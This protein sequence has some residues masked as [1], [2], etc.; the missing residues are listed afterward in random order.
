MPFEIHLTSPRKS[1]QV[2]EADSRERRKR[3]ALEVIAR[4]HARRARKIGSKRDRIV[5]RALAQLKRLEEKI[6][7]D[8]ASLS[9]AEHSKAILG[10]NQLYFVIAGKP[11]LTKNHII[12]LVRQVRGGVMSREDALKSVNEWV[13]QRL[14]F[15]KEFI[16]YAGVKKVPSWWTEALK[17]KGS[18]R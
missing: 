13:M 1:H 18:K 17:R 9:P 5:G 7:S 2:I 14:S 12:S 8:L 11:R 15:F 10:L 16:R 6:E 3:H 4:K